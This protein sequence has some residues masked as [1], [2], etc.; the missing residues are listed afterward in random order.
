M[1]ERDDFLLSHYWDALAAG[2]TDAV[3][4]DRSIAEPL[5]QVHSLFAT[6]KPGAARERARQ[7]VFKSVS[8]SKE[9]TMSAVSVSF[10]IPASNGRVPHAAA[11]EPYGASRS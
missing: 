3:E 8:T 11:R 6:P 4:I 1:T 7:R 2:D 10:P 5:R 9:N